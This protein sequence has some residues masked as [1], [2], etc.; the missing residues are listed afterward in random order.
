[1]HRDIKLDNFIFRDETES[2]PLT[3][4]DFGYATTVQRG[5]ETMRDMGVGTPLYIEP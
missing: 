5:D 4:I 2:S 1:M 3:L